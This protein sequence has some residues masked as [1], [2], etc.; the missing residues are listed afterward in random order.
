V[1]CAQLPDA[2]G[3]DVA[4]G[5]GDAVLVAVGVAAPT[6]VDVVRG[7]TGDTGVVLR[8]VLD[9][10]GVGRDGDGSATDG[11]GMGVDGGVDPMGDWAALHAA[12]VDRGGLL[13][14][15]D[16]ASVAAVPERPPAV[17]Q[18]AELAAN[19]SAR[20]ATVQR[21]MNLRSQLW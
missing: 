5:L 2:A 16:E 10:V 8:L 19:N 9:T 21:R 1:R 3:A 17:E 7:G 11:D 18:E 13:A 4:V 14:G 15:I 12:A 6:G 20:T